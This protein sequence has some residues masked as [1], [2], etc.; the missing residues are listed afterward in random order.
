MKKYVYSTL[1]SA[2]LIATMSTQVFAETANTTSEN[3]GATVTSVETTGFSTG[4]VI[5]AIEPT[6]FTGLTPNK[7]YEVRYTDS[8][9]KS[10]LVE[11]IMVF[12]K[13]SYN[14]ITKIARPTPTLILGDDLYV[15]M[16]ANNPYTVG[17][18]DYDAFEEIALE[19][20]Y[21]IENEIKDMT[22]INQVFENLLGAKLN[23]A[24]LGEFIFIQDLV[25]D[26]MT[27]LKFDMYAPINEDRTE[28]D[29]IGTFTLDIKGDATVKVAMKQD[30]AVNPAFALAQKILLSHEDIKELS[31]ITNGY[32]Y[33]PVRAY[34]D[35]ANYKV[36]YDSKTNSVTLS[37]GNVNYVTQFG[38]D[39]VTKI[40]GSNK[41]T[42]TNNNPLYSVDGVGYIPIDFLINGVNN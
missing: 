35:F 34:A 21:Y 31:V 30:V 32:I 13:N 39:E 29:L 16:K 2:A 11:T 15:A 6:S 42:Y 38:S 25:T 4:V 23:E 10:T 17:T 9:G 18:K 3:I 24:V 12:D 27:V 36:N 14:S 20:S 26:K 5:V 40:D 7:A 33:M 28:Y 41:V 19:N 22:R 1:I 37:R 8:E